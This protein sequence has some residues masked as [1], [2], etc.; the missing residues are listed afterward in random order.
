M[1]QKVNP[2]SMRLGVIRTWD[3]IWF[4][5]KE[6][7]NYLLEDFKIRKFVLDNYGRAF[8][9]KVEIARFPSLVKVTICAAKPGM[10]IGRKGSEIEVISKKLSKI[11]KNKKVD[12]AVKEIKIPELDAFVV[13]QD[14]ARQIEHKISYK[15]AIKQAIRNAM[16]A[17]AKGIRIRVSG[18]LNG[19]EIARS[20]EFKEGQI[21]L[22]TLAADID[23]R[24]SESMTDMGVVGI[25]V[26]IYR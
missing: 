24:V 1:G 19:A 16:K 12:V 26:W 14:I 22:S 10:I 8:I 3:S 6:Y 2:N 18:R 21:P 25:K 11:V 4:S 20:E 9:S 23:Y 15:R 5:E 17:N 7:V 13:G